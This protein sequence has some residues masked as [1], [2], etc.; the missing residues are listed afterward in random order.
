MSRHDRE[1]RRGVPDPH[2]LGRFD[3]QLVLRHSGFDRLRL[4]QVEP[5]PEPDFFTIAVEHR[6]DSEEDRATSL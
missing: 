4:A 1:P 5:E 3:V 6:D 2:P